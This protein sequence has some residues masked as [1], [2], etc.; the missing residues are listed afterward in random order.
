MKLWGILVLLIIL[1]TGLAS[2]GSVVTQ[3]KR[4]FAVFDNMS[5]RGKPDTTRDGLVLSNILY[6]ASIWPHD[7]NYGVLPSRDAFDAL[8]S[9]HSANPGPL[10]LDIERLP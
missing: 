5:Y 6:E 10:V 2:H 9:T 7:K 8:V 4:S 1:D 3:E